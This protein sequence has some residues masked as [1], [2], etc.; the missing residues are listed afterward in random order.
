V[1]ALAYPLGG[2]FHVPHGLS[3]ALVMTQVLRFNLSNAQQWYAELAQT[4]P[5]QDCPAE[6][7]GAAAYFIDQMERLI[8]ETGIARTLREVGVAQ[9]D[10]PMLARDAMQQ[11]RL[12]M[13]NPRPVTEADALA[14]Y[15]AAF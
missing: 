5:A 9:G 15:Q 8:A 12:L 13:N 4:L 1:H 7:A 14:I 11:Q 3:N 6:Q 10:L 2:H